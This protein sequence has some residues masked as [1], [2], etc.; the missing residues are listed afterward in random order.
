MH[1][2]EKL[3][4]SR[5]LRGFVSCLLPVVLAAPLPAQDAAASATHDIVVA[6]EQVTDRA[7]DIK[8]KFKESDPEWREARDRYRKAFAEFNAYIAIVKAAIRKGK[9]ED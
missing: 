2:A 9:A 7:L 1:H 6:R 5:I 4:S 3:T 8:H